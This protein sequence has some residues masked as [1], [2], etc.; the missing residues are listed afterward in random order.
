MACTVH[1][2]P[3]P[4]DTCSAERPGGAKAGAVS[5]TGRPWSLAIPFAWAV[6]ALGAVPLRLDFFDGRHALEH[7]AHVANRGRSIDP[8]AV[9]PNHCGWIVGLARVNPVPNLDELLWRLEA[10]EVVELVGNRSKGPVGDILEHQDNARSAQA[11]AGDSVGLAPGRHGLAAI[12]D[13]LVELLEERQD[14]HGFTPASSPNACP[15]LRQQDRMTGGWGQPML[16]S[17]RKNGP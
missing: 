8:E 14:V 6:V 11:V 16:L 3:C 13:L 5:R 9:D 17:S 10:L 12:P 15:R 4:V 2:G 1:R 7:P